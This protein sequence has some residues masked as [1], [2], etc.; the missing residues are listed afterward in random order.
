MTLNIP[1]YRGLKIFTVNVL[2][3]SSQSPDLNPV[4]LWHYLKIVHQ[5]NP[6]NLK[7]PK[8]FCLEELAKIPMAGVPVAG[9][10][11]LIETYLKSLAIAAN[12]CSA[13]LV[14]TVYFW[15]QFFL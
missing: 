1:L 12:S 10:A 13:I 5:R 8:Q 14:H 4:D 11:K 3:W 6:S 9:C 15:I 2:E 7:E